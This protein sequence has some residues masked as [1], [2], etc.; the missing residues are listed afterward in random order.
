M[1]CF[2]V[3]VGASHGSFL[4]YIYAYCGFLYHIDW[5]VLI[6]TELLPRRGSLR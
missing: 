6:N 2:G 3:D 1:L 5:N 4:L